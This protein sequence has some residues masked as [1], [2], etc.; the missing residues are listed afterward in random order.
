MKISKTALRAIIIT[1]VLTGISYVAQGC[2]FGSVHPRAI[3]V[4]YW[5]V[6]SLFGVSNFTMAILYGALTIYGTIVLALAYL[7][8]LVV[9]KRSEIQPWQIMPVLYAV[10]IIVLVLLWLGV[11]NLIRPTA[12]IR[13]ENGLYV[14][15]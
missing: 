13:Y 11:P 7:L 2:Q 4:V 5:N 14:E 9:K 12:T 8:Y 6:A 3:C 10:P 1:I 15:Y